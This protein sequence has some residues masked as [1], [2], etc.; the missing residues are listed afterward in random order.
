MTEQIQFKSIRDFKAYA[1]KL[2]EPVRSLILSAKDEMTEDEFLN[3]FIEWRK[4]LR[5]KKG[6]EK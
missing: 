4:L 3:K 2:P 1:E 5:M 6:E